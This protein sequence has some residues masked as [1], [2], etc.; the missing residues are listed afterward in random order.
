MSNPFVKIWIL[1]NSA[2]IILAIWAG[3]SFG[4]FDPSVGLFSQPHWWLLILIWITNPRAL[5]VLYIF[6]AEPAV[7][8]WIS[9]V[10]IGGLLV[11]G[12]WGLYFLPGLSANHGLRIFLGFVGFFIRDVVE[13]ELVEKPLLGI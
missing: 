8:H 2:G 7:A 9:I 3:V 6:C 12:A 5:G 11:P 10:I 13:K 4:T 1:L